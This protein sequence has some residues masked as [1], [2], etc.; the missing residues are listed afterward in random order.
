MKSLFVIRSLTC[1]LFTLSRASLEREDTRTQPMT[2]M[3]VENDYITSRR[4]VVIVTK[5]V[6]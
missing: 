4:V 2:E 1:K 5:C 6:C 3:L